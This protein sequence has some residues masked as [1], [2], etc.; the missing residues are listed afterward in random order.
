MKCLVTICQ[1][2]R[3]VLPYLFGKYC[4]PRMQAVFP[5]EMLLYH[6]FHDYAGVGPSYLQSNLTL[7]DDNLKNVKDFIAQGKYANAKVLRHEILYKEYTYLPSVALAATVAIHERADFHL[8]LED[9]AIVLDSG[10]DQWPA[11]F[12]DGDVGLYRD[13]AYKGM[14]NSA[15]FV[16]RTSFDRRLLPRLSEYVPDN[17]P[18]S[19]SGQLEDLLCQCA[20]GTTLL[21]RED[22]IRYHISKKFPTS[23]EDVEAWLTRRLGVTPDELDLLS[24]DYGRYASL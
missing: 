17:K 7:G 11:L 1:N 20:A 22:A 4:L 3:A 10:C 14:V 13:T 9:D 5:G 12:G 24:L 19:E 15:Y 6:I 23:L 8:W 21:R 16:S 18:H 2:K